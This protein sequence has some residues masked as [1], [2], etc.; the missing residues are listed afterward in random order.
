M[1]HLPWV[2]AN[3]QKAVHVAA[4]NSSATMFG[5]YT[6]EI[7]PAQL[8]DLGINWT[9]LGHSER[10]QYYHECSETI[11]KKSKLA[12]DNKLKVIAC[13]GEQLEDRNGG[14]AFTV[15]ENQL[16]PLKS[17]IPL[18]SYILEL[19]SEKDWQD[20]VIAY[21]PVWAIGTG[22][23]A[24]PE[25]AQEVHDFIRK[26]LASGVSAQVAASTRIIYGGSVTEKNSDILLKKKDIDGFLV[27]FL[28]N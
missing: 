28:Y 9:I 7:A 19:L 20:V 1:L 25:Q 17:T 14:K 16:A 27:L 23:V 21:E 18:Y 5:A 24:S 22:V 3:V 10:R 26:Y 2:Q 13:V 8:K 15:I 4:Q 12:I 11:A 6:G